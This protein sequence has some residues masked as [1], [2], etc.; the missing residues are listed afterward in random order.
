MPQKKRLRVYRYTCDI[1]GK[2]IESI[3]KKQVEHNLK[4]HKLTHEEKK[5]PKE[6]EEGTK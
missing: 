5:E 2:V 1:C 3:Y 4:V 6:I